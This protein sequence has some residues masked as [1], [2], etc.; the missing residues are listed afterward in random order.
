MS[1]SL[2]CFQHWPRP[3]G[4]SLGQH[5]HCRHSIRW[6][7]L[8]F[9]SLTHR[10]PTSH[11]MTGNAFFVCKQVEWNC[12]GIVIDAH[13]NENKNS[14]ARRAR[15]NDSK[16][17][18]YSFQLRAPN[19]RQWWIAAIIVDCLP[20]NHYTIIWCCVFLVSTHPSAS[21]LKPFMYVTCSIKQTH[22][23]YA[24]DA[25]NSFNGPH[26]DLYLSF[27]SY[28]CKLLATQEHQT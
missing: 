13:K 18:V 3:S 10:N 1:L 17:R 14:I 28:L 5:E 26:Y 12:I 27:F 24:S 15:V 11:Q 25:I 23:Y 7:L 8:C 4:A 16:F 19:C 20:L 6:N 21:G 2:C 9:K 22:K